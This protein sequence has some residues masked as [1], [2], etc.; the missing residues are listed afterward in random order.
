MER[1]AILSDKF[2]PIPCGGI[3]SANYSLYKMFKSK[4]YEVKVFTYLEDQAQLSG[5][6]NEPDIIRFGPSSLEKKYLEFSNILKRKI[7]KWILRRNIEKG[8]AYQLNLVRL[9]NYGSRRINKHLKKFSPNFVFIPDF[10]A[11]GYSLEKKSG[12]IYFHFSHHNPSRFVGNPMLELH[13]ESDA[14]DAIRYEQLSLRKMDKVVCPSEYMK[15]IFKNTFSFNKEIIVLPNL[16]DEEFINNV[17]IKDIHSI[18]CI[19][20]SW[21]IVYIPSAGSKLKGEQFVIEIIRRI[22]H[23]LKNEVGFYL[24]GYLSEIQKIELSYFPDFHIYSP[25]KV[26]LETNIS[27]IKDCKILISPTLIECF[28]MAILESLFCNIPCVAFDVG[29]NEEIIKDNN[30]YLFRYLD[31]ESLIAKSIEIIQNEEL[32]QTLV[33]NTKIT[34][35]RYSTETVFP[36]YLDL[37]K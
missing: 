37:L 19:D 31:I 26:N 15:N 36:K 5:L 7:N 28:G 20:P 6:E 12:A 18:L 21:P 22:S 9:A 32:Y 24:S 4:G 30:G 17:I 14:I 33:R 13:S 29:G 2:P 3:G 34:Q 16:I 27:Y 8:L 23:K 1:I 25:G 35:K 11:P 10:G